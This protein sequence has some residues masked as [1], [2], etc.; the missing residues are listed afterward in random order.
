MRP[1]A[2]A[3][4]KEQRQESARQYMARAT[5]QYTF[6]DAPACPDYMPRPNFARLAAVALVILSAT[7]GLGWTLARKFEPCECFIRTEAGK[8]ER[9]PRL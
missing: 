7:L 1:S 3:S 2:L 5:P 6:P 8:I 4:T 9:A